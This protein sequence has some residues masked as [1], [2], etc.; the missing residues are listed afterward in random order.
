VVENWPTRILFSGFEIGEKVITG[1]RLAATPAPNPV[2]RAYQLFHDSV[3]S[4]R[5]SW[6]LITVLAAVRGG[7]TFWKASCDGYCKVSPT[8][9]NEW[10]SSPNR[11]HAYLR[12]EALSEEIANEL[13]DFLAMPPGMNSAV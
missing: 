10:A 5:P 2:K 6:D 4:G 8:G 1:K 13:D 3:A 12:Q 11:G 7:G 9:T